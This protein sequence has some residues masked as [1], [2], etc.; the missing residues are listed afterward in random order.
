M[1]KSAVSHANLNKLSRNNKSKKIISILS[2]FLELQNCD[3]LE[4]GTGSGYIIRDLS[5]ISKSGSSVDINDERV[6][7]SGYSFRKLNDEHLPFKDNSFD[8]V[9][10]NHVIEHLPNQELH[11]SALH[12]KTYRPPKFLGYRMDLISNIQN[13][14]IKHNQFYLL[15]KWI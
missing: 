10:S 6:I 8:I 11:L 15:S 2:E 4:I 1:T 3:I 7:K 9:I 5:K 12:G 14:K 13:Y